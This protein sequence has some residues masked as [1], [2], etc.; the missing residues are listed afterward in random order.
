MNPITD[1]LQGIAV[2]AIA[3]DALGMPLEF[4]PIRPI[5]DLETEMIA[6]PLPAGTF[7]DDTEMALALA[8]SLL[9]HFPL[10]ADDLAERFAAWYTSDP[11]DVG[12]HTSLVLEKIAN[13]V[14]W[15][16]AAQKVQELDPE[17]AGN[18][19]LMRGWPLVIARWQQPAQLVEESRLQSLVTHPHPDC[20]N[21]CVFINLMLYELVHRPA[22]I[23]PNAAL[24]QAVAAAVEQV[25][26]DPDFRL[27]VDLAPVRTR[28][29]LFNS[30]WVRHT[31]EAS[32]WAVLTTRSF[33]EALVQAVNLGN[34]ADT[35]GAVTGAIAGALYGLKAIPHRWRDALRG[36]YPIRSGCNWSVSDF[37]TLADR[38]SHSERGDEESFLLFL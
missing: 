7:T 11:S 15:Q 12:I 22:D 21:A 4:H 2:G 30:G 35:T 19:S 23:P 32:L 20:V 9:S 36:E 37:I 26:L 8:E 18:G 33:E 29:T 27:L 14:S 34:D 10:D 1:R 3:G 24:R 31:V 16:E 28:E 6:G 5:Y 38:L 13:G 17:S 25:E